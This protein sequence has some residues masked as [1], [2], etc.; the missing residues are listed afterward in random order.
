MIAA[1]EA[2]ALEH[3]RRLLVVEMVE[4]A[5]QGLAVERDDRRPAGSAGGSK[6]A[7]VA[8]EGVFQGSA[9]ERLQDGAQRVDHGARFRVQPKAALRHRRRC[10]RKQ[11]MRR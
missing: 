11:M 10:S 7:G 4:A 6:A 1:L 9:V 5:P 3:L 2:K 8:A